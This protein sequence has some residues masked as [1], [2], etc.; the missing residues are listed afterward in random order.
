MHEFSITNSILSILGKIADDRKLKRIKKIRLILNPMGGIEKESLKFYFKFL[1]KDNPLFKDCRLVFK[2]DILRAVCTDC[3][4]EFEI[5]LKR[6]GNCK[7]C[8]SRNIKIIPADDIRI[9]S[10]DV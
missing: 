9:L 7:S 8:N 5:S 6:P 4:A 1:T 3:G 10:I 2:K